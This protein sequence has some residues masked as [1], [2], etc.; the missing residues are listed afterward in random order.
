M[1]R[2]KSTVQLKSA[3]VGR[4]LLWLL[5]FALAFDGLST[6][7]TLIQIS[8]P[9]TP[10]IITA[11]QHLSRVPLIAV[12]LVCSYLAIILLSLVWIYRLHKDLR[13]CYGGY[14]ID[15]EHVLGRSIF[16]G[17]NIW[18]IWNTLM[19]IARH[20]KAEADRL[21]HYGLLLQRL[22]P[23]M[24]S[25]FT[26]WYLLD[27]L[28]YKYDGVVRIEPII[29][30]PESLVP[31]RIAGQELLSLGMGFVLLAITQTIF[32][33]MQLKVHQIRSAAEPSQESSFIQWCLQRVSLSAGARNTV[34]VLLA[35]AGTRDCTLAAKKL[36][37]RTEL[38]LSDEQIADVRP[39]AGLTN[40]EQL[41]LSFN[42]ITD[43]TPLATL[44]NLKQLFL[45]HNPIAD[46]SPLAKLTN[47]KELFLDHNQ[48]ADVSPLSGLTNLKEL[49]INNNQITDVS[50]LATLTNLERLDLRFNTIRNI[51]SVAKLT[52][53]KELF[54]D[55]N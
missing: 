9:V 23:L 34:E 4:V 50:P 28:R 41:D 17:F 35:E 15:A 38:N 54:L 43:V 8:L 3:G 46:V 37:S 51:S 11:L 29:N 2:S 22:V 33:A 53:L 26:A 47:L 52:N 32:N 10:P 12:L 21:H 30:I 20:F 31:V 49:D 1:K 19:T 45:D 55:L 25:I 18:G 13:Q 24:Y 39:L 7:L 16:P 5:R 48:I 40:L 6:I 42:T 36:L 14:P 44:T 27:Q